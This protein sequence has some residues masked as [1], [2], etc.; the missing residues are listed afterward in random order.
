M[1]VLMICASPNPDGST[2]SILKDMR[3]QISEKGD[4]VEWLDLAQMQIAGCR[5]CRSCQKDGH[6]AIHD[7]MAKVIDGMVRADVVVLGSPVY[8]G[9]E[10]GQTKCLIDRLYC[11]FQGLPDGTG[12]GRLPP[13]KRAITLLTCALSDG[14]RIYAYENTK[15][16]KVFVNMLGFDFVLSSIVPGCRDPSLVMQN[17]FATGAISDAM[18]FLYP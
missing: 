6:C 2:A 13:G 18:A 10:T 16:F 7:D 11:L 12:K 17:R 9:A 3:R 8:M 14:D 1:N 15:F 5:G 4:R